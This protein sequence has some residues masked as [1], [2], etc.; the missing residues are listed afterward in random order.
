MEKVNSQLPYTTNNSIRLKI[1]AA[2]II[3]SKLYFNLFGT[4]NPIKPDN[5]CTPLRNVI[6][7]SWSLLQTT[8]VRSGGSEA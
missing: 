8:R 2:T 5:N 4:K 6:V 7:D 3:F 1:K